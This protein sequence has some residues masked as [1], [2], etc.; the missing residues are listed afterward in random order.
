MRAKALVFGAVITLAT[1]C[2]AQQGSILV[3]RHAERVSQTADELSDAGKARAECLAVTLKDV[4]LTS[5]LTSDAKR[6]QE[7]AEPTAVEQKLRVNPL[8]ASQTGTIVEE[9]RRQARDGRVL[10]VGHGD[11]IPQIVKALTGKTVRVGAREYD[12]LFVIDGTE[13]MTLHYCPTTQSE[14]ESKMR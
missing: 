10:I 1:V 13:V 2:A 11:T 6:T 4:K 5:I 12:Q 9:A 7:T 8:P 14:P 3:V